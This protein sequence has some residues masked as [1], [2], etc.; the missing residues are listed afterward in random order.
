MKDDDEFS[1]DDQYAAAI[2]AEYHQEKMRELEAA[3]REA[4]YGSGDVL[5]AGN[6][7]SRG[8]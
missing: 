6:E 5:F 4:R 3:H 2:L 8:N 7:P 1:S